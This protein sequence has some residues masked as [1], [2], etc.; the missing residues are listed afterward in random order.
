MKLGQNTWVIV[1]VVAVIIA[2]SLVV[3]YY[4]KGFK[5]RLIKLAIEEYVLF[6][7]GNMKE[8][9]PIAREQIEKYWKYG[10]RIS[11]QSPTAVPWSAVFISYIFRVAG[12]G[13]LFNY[14]MRHSD[15]IRLSV[16][17]RKSDSLY[18]LKGYKPTEV[19]VE[20]GDL[21]CHARQSG[22]TYDSDFNYA[23]HC[24]IVV[25]VDLKRGK[26]NLIGGN[27]SNSVNDTEYNVDSK[28]F[29]QSSKPHVII[30]NNI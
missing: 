12:A 11:P 8:S 23:A 2:A 14:S 22:V 21:V 5:K 9:E 10:A 24:D 29:I 25:N 15:Y 17:A 7:E 28:G 16:K 30:K 6:R 13:P 27:V 26:A 19:P 4:K 18:P 20:V 1:I 3:Y